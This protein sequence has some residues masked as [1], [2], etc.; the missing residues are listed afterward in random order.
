MEVIAPSLIP[1]RSSACIKQSACVW[2]FLAHRELHA[3]LATC[4]WWPRNCW[5]RTSASGAQPCR[6]K[7]LV[8]PLKVIALFTL[9]FATLEK[10]PA[11]VWTLF[12]HSKL[13]GYLTTDTQRAIV[14]VH[15]N[16]ALATRARLIEMVR[17][18]KARCQGRLSVCVHR[19]AARQHLVLV[20]KTCRCKIFSRRRNC[21]VQGRRWKGACR[22]CGK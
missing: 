21:P 4:T 8:S 7:R 18:T 22:P 10:H 16:N 1:L 5:S 9:W 15:G 14:K 3:W 13:H 17:T 19:H 11:H 12:A 20:R 6:T 2:S